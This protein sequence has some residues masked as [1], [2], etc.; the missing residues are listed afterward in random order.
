MFPLL[1]EIGK[2]YMNEIVS[3][4]AEWNIDLNV[5]CPHCEHYFDVTDYISMCEIPCDVGISE[6]DIM[7]DIVC[8]ECS[9]EFRIDDVTS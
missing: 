8:P 6:K 5:T 3:C 1:A 2:I 9:R 4:N 7:F